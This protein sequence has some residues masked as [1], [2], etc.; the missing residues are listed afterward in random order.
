MDL[1]EGMFLSKRFRAWETAYRSLYH[2]FCCQTCSLFYGNVSDYLVSNIALD[3]YDVSASTSMIT[4]NRR[5]RW[6]VC[7]SRDAGSNN[8]FIFSVSEFHVATS[9]ATAYCSLMFIKLWLPWCDLLLT[10][11]LRSWD[12]YTGL[13]IAFYGCS[14]YAAICCNVCWW[15]SWRKKSGC[16]Y[17][18]LDPLNTRSATSSTWIC[19][20]WLKVP[21][22]W[23]SSPYF[24]STWD[25]VLALYY[26]VLMYI[27]MSE[28]VLRLTGMS[29][30]NVYDAG[31]NL[32]AF[33]WASLL[34][35][36]QKI[37]AHL[38]LPKWVILIVV[39]MFFGVW[40]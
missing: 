21:S 24:R 4:V 13:M 35:N 14:L 39:L 3:V 22:V 5:C 18:I 19:K 25:Y 30:H 12:L 11:G 38:E 29:V 23:S 28:G 10:V 6:G 20:S 8:Q 17:C 33:P 37:L 1:A 15:W 7:L 2:N 36:N 26:Y 27:E 31:T 40:I 16:L 34:W 9:T 32:A